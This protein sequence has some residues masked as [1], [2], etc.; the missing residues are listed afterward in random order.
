M[1]ALKVLF[2][3]IETSP[4]TAH[5]WRP[6][7]QYVTMDRLI[8][9]SYM[10]NWGAKW[11]DGDKVLTGLVTPQEARERDDSRIVPL[12][13]DLV[14]QADYAVGHNVNGFDW[15]R[16]NARVAALNLEP[17]GPVATIDTLQLSKKNLGLAYHKLDYLGEYFGLGRKLKTDM[18]LWLRCMAGERAALLEM[19][20]YNIQDVLLLEQ[21]FNRLKP[22]VRRFPRLHDADS[23]NA[24]SCPFCGAGFESM[25]PRGF[26]RTQ[27][28][29]MA[30]YR[31]DNCGKYSRA[32]TTERGKKIGVHP[33]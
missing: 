16:L 31:C 25:K 28:S 22:H 15:P 26:Y 21:V 29:T 4:L 10:L 33:L 24:R 6:T 19:R 9:D 2:F 20:D 18:E 11:A 5:I 1:T 23:E 3:D 30:K 27:A 7:D 13:A 17:L 8:Q 14:R 32:R 12:L